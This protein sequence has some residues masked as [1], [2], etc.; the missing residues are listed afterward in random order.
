MEAIL[1]KLVI[2]DVDG[3]LTTGKKY[4]NRE[5][6]VKLKSFCDKDWTSIKRF[7][8]IG[9]PVIFI[10][11][12]PYNKQI[13]DN[14]N[15]ENY[16][17]RSGV[18]RE[19]FKKDEVVEVLDKAELLPEICEKYDC[20]VREIV[21]AGDDLLDIGIMRKIEWTFCPQDA[22]QMVKDIA[23]STLKQN[24]GDNFVVALF[25]SLEVLK[26]IPTYSF[27]EV[28]D[29]IYALDAKEKF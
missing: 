26:L 22:P 3:V 27:D 15:L 25:E 2:L 14:R 13:L 10:T 5:G 29:K 8:A 17:C 6:E 12:D 19:E 1:I 18:F 16:I 9:I 23:S 20:S 21:Y 4:Y 7:Q 24:G 11:G 28:I